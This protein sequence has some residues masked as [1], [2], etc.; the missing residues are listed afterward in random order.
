MEGVS[1]SLNDENQFSE[2]SFLCEKAVQD[3]VFP[4]CIVSVSQGGKELYK[5]AFGFKSVIRDKDDTPQPVELSTI[6]DI[7]SLTN[8]FV[9]TTIIMR[10]VQ[11]NR[12]SLD[13]KVSRFIQGF[14]VNGK[15]GV[16]IRQLLNHSSGLAS[17]VPFYEELVKLNEGERRGILTS[18]GA[19]D[20]IFN[21]INRSQ[22]KFE[23]GTKQVYSDV[24][25]L[26]LG[27]L[28][29]IV[30]GMRLARAA[31]QYVFQ[32]LGLKSTSF[33]DLAMV[34]RG[35]IH[36]VK[37]IIAPTENCEWRGHLLCGEVFD[38]NAWAMGGVAGNSGVF[39]NQSDLHTFACQIL[40]SYNGQGDF[41]RPDVLQEFLKRPD[42]L[43]SDGWACGWE[44][45]N[46]D[47]LL[48]DSK[49]SENAI[50]F[51]SV[52]G[53]SLWLEPLRGID[54]VLMSNR[55]HPSRANKKIRNFRPVLIDAILSALEKL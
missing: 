10:L 16:T 25:F 28:I 35:G 49:L 5:S 2:V 20:Y 32:P 3:G 11:N 18:S 14:A 42:S 30:T 15:S 51:D 13:D 41:I 12:L 24:G 23:P 4:G 29:E 34:R 44:R 31:Q 1:F 17:S 43:P 40:K 37:D 6:F 26:L 50:G 33:I 47:N 7:S 52:T 39:C 46:K 38:D 45:P 21:S 53:C 27:F 48:S 36:P 54:I 22:L 55:V 8:V 9:T 19:R